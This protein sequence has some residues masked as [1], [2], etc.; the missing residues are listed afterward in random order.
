MPL[1]CILQAR[2]SHFFPPKCR[3]LV[4]Q[5]IGRRQ[6]NTDAQS[7]H[8]IGPALKAKTR[9]QCG[10][11]VKTNGFPRF[12]N[13]LCSQTQFISNNSTTFKFPLALVL[14]VIHVPCN[15]SVPGGFRAERIH[16]R[17]LANYWSTLLWESVASSG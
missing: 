10:T 13:S 1:V 6:H 17:H 9:A 11:E 14:A 2:G 3:R 12:A 4:G 7:P 8:S 15:Y 5:K 16:T